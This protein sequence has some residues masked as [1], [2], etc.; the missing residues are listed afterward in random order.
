MKDWV[1]IEVMKPEAIMK[2]KAAEEIT[3]W[4]G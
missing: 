3:S 1:G 2:E 4:D